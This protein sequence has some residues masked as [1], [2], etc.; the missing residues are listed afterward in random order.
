MKI[1]AVGRF[2]LETI[3][4]SCTIVEIGRERKIL[5]GN[6]QNI[7]GPRSIAKESRM[8]YLNKITSGYWRRRALRD[9]ETIRPRTT[10]RVDSSK[11]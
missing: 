2:C 7:V 8:L 4:I 10:C 5:H 1:Q 11:I 6:R 3:R 9:M